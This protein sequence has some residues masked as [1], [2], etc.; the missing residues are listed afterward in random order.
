MNK[1]HIINAINGL[2]L[3]AVGLFSYFSNESRPFTA[4]IGP[5][6]GLIFLAS[7]SGMK[8]GDKNIAHIVAGLTLLFM[9]VCFVQ[10]GLSINFPDEI[11][12]QRRLFTFGIMGISNLYATSY[13]VRR[14]IWIKKQK[15]EGK[16]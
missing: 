9:I 10:F 12:R 3:I 1:Q 4:L 7:T 13:Y 15:K 8:K 16:I 2:I 6:I 5:I 11:A 14:F